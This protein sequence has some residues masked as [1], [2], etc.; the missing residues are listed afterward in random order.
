MRT[1]VNTG[2]QPEARSRQTEPPEKPGR[3]I[4]ARVV[5]S[6]VSPSIS[7]G[8]WRHLLT[9]NRASLATVPSRSALSAAT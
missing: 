1:T 5:I 6:L 7:T 2:P 3:F 4:A 8:S 9:N